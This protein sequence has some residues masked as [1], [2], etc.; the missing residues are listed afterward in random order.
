[1]S[2]HTDPETG[3]WVDD[4]RDTS[5]EGFQAENE[6]N[7]DSSGA[8]SID[9]DSDGGSPGGI[10]E[11]GPP[12]AV[13]TADFEYEV[14]AGNRVKFVST[15]V[16]EVGSCIWQFGDSQSLRDDFYP[17]HQYATTGDF[18]VNYYVSN[19]TGQ[20]EPA[21]KTVTIPV[22]PAVEAVSFR[23]Y[24]NGLGV[25]F[26]NTSN[27]NGQPFWSFGVSGS[28]SSVSSPSYLYPLAGTYQ[29]T[30]AIGNL[31]STE[32]IAVSDATTMDG[33]GELN[34]PISIALDATC[35]YVVD[36]NN[37][38]VQIFDITT[39]EYIGQF[40]SFGTGDGQFADPTDIAVDATNIYVCESK[41]DGNNRVQIFNKTTYAFVGKFG[42]AGAG[43]GQGGFYCVEVDDNYIYC[44]DG[45]NKRI[46][47]FNKTTYAFVGKFGSPGSGPGQ[48]TTAD[49]IYV[50]D[51]RIFT[52]G[53]TDGRI[54]VFNKSTYAFIT[55]F[56]GFGSAAGLFGNAWG[57][58]GDSSYLYVTDYGYS[59]YGP[60][61][62]GRVQ[63][64][65]KST[66]AYVGQIG[67]QG[68]K[69][70]ELDAP[71]GN[72]VDDT[73]IFVCD[74]R[75]NEGNFAVGFRVQVFNKTTGAYIAQFGLG[76]TGT[77]PAEVPTSLFTMDVSTGVSPLTVQFT[78][79]S[80]GNPTQ[81]E[82]TFGD[83]FT[84]TLQH[85]V[86]TFE[87]PGTFT[88]KQK[89][90]NAYASNTSRQDVAVTQAALENTEPIVKVTD[91]A[92][93]ADADADI[94]G[95]TQIFTYVDGSANL[96][97]KV[98]TDA[99]T[100]FTSQT[101]GGYPLGTHYST[102]LIFQDGVSGNRRLTAFY[103]T[104]LN[105]MR[106]LTQDSTSYT[107]PA[108]TPS[109]I[110]GS[111]LTGKYCTIIHDN[112]TGCAIVE[113]VYYDETN[114]QLKH[115]YSS[116]SGATWLVS[117]INAAGDG[118]TYCGGTKTQ[119]YTVVT[120][121]DTVTSKLKVAYRRTTY[122]SDA[123][124]IS[125][126]DA[127][128]VTLDRKITAYVH[129][130]YAGT[131]T[132]SY[133]WRLFIPYY[134][135]TG[136]VLNIANAVATG[137]DAPG[138]WTVKVAD[139]TSVP[140]RGTLVPI[141]SNNDA[142]SYLYNYYYFYATNGGATIKVARLCSGEIAWTVADSGLT[143]APLISVASTYAYSNDVTYTVG[144]IT[145]KSTISKTMNYGNLF[146]STGGILWMTN[147]IPP[148]AY[149]KFVTGS[150]T[151]N[152]SSYPPSYTCGGSMIAY[153]AGTGI[154]LS[155]DWGDSTALAYDNP[156]THTYSVNTIAEQNVTIRLSVSNAYG[157]AVD[158][159]D[160]K[161]NGLDGFSLVGGSSSGFIPNFI[162]YTSRTGSIPGET[163]DSLFGKIGYYMVDNENSQVRI[164]GL[165]GE[166]LRVV[167]ELGSTDGK[168][169]R[170]STC[171]V[172]NGKQQLDRVESV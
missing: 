73:R 15:A 6:S 23:Y 89:V 109:T 22:T 65:N 99:G 4:Y 92:V 75:S 147:F 85:P 151:L 35:A 39:Y 144:S 129:R 76:Y 50:D 121:L 48:F 2:G 153:Y 67:K 64:F 165:D 84:S 116:D 71:E 95:N 96:I 68:L 77:N 69:N 135:T 17:E 53:W 138:T 98:S 164:H 110:D 131:E 61:Y 146:T 90:T 63:V 141:L 127:G 78:D 148:W 5:V 57:I 128:P 13:P 115:A 62:N 119:G 7:W 104:S 139:T 26:V 114:D 158:S 163:L 59:N 155:W 40:G 113:I 102:K 12:M 162:G 126:L 93:P 18:T 24:K 150:G 94:R 10:S 142:D 14:L 171:C 42:T 149:A 27:V 83:G 100:T 70:G 97:Q 29:V 132:Y 38:R 143:G 145:S 3:Q 117:A 32:S 41:T 74:T 54:Q 51:T 30:L 36:E 156:A 168:F 157:T 20:S 107:L 122:T 103:D 159:I 66:Y 16:G 91:A 56:G 120:W 101:F 28:S 86:H 33:D 72:A 43:D 167:G 81:W 80:L 49:D 60:P 169:N 112:Y 105:T 137:G 79:K 47:I 1:M 9:F 125:D 37:F 133:E 111:A 136:S 82:W 161:M 88:T 160:A 134:N 130:R 108:P 118:G 52:A 44:S 170:P 152:N 25:V 123:W 11:V 8:K 45:D 19:S 87:R 124:T 166:Q 106:L 46:Q 172:V 58:A 140:L 21:T 55:E 31:S 34:F 154:S